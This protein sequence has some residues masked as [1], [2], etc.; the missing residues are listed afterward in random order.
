MEPKELKFSYSPPGGRVSAAVAQLLNPKLE[1]AV[2]S[3]LESFKEH[4]E[5]S[6]LPADPAS[7][8]G[9]GEMRH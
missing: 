7:R 8:S 3:D 4:I 1:E 9:R 5:T 6:G 2:H